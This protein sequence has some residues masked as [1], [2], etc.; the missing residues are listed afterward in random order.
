[1]VR[2]IVYSINIAQAES[3]AKNA[4]AQLQTRGVTSVICA[5]DP[6]F[7]IFLVGNA[8]SQKYYP[9]WLALD[10]GDIF[11]QKVSPQS[12]WKDNISGGITPP[13]KLQQEAYHAYK[14]I[15]PTGTPSPEF[16]A[17]Y[18]PLLQL[19]SGL[20]AAGPDLTP[21][22]FAEG[23]FTMPPSIPG[24]EFGSWKYGQNTY[25]PVDSFQ[26]L[27]WS[28]TTISQ[29]DNLPGTFVAC[30]NAR[31][32]TFSMSGATA[33]PNHRQLICPKS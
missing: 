30:N 20:Q 24:G 28:P 18:A 25:S 29:Q 9:E 14:L 16:A 23:L 6:L 4:I 19:F 10:F 31:V 8:T 3:Q 2:Q 21:Q 1:V 11:G 33:L 15:D 22:T 32:Y 27:R 13:P 5:C 7:P 17:I 26:V 12:Q